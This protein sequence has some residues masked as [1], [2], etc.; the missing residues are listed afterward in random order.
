[1]HCTICKL[2]KIDVSKAAKHSTGIVL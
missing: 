1:M 2:Y